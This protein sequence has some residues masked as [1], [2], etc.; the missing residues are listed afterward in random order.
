MNNYFSDLKKIKTWRRWRPG[1]RPLCFLLKNIP[2]A[3]VPFR[4]RAQ[5][6]PGPTWACLLLCSKMALGGTRV[7]LEAE[8]WSVLC[9]FGE[10]WGLCL[11]L[12]SELRLRSQSL[13][14]ISCHHVCLL[15]LSFVCVT[16][17]RESDEDPSMGHPHPPTP[18]FVASSLGSISGP[19]LSLLQ[20][21]TGAVSTD[22]NGMS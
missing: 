7:W 20:F 9:L 4:P 14:S 13:S 16:H 6:V 18:V 10:W 11:L 21:V 2:S 3:Q 8:R 1:T 22:A 5:Q 15:P 17:F 19:C 12:F